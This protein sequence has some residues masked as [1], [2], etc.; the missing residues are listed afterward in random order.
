MSPFEPLYGIPPPIHVPYFPKDSSIVGV[1]I[2]LRAQEAALEVLK[3][4]LKKVAHRM[5]VQTDKHR[6]DRE[7][8]ICDWVY[9]KLQSY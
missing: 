3:F 4:Q 8:Q 2:F 1:D 5:K 9:L 6:T 7:Y